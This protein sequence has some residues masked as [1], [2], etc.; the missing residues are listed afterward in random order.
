MSTAPCPRDI[1]LV[2]D[3]CQRLYPVVEDSSARRISHR[4]P[5]MRSSGDHRLFGDIK[6]GTTFQTR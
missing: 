1:Q 5:D 6:I 3:F 2:Q 4:D